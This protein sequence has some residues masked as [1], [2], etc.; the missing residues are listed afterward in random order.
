MGT[1]C[2]ACWL[3]ARVERRRVKQ[4]RP[5]SLSVWTQVVVTACLSLSG[6]LQALNI[7]TVLVERGAGPFVAGLWL[8]LIAAGLQ[9][10]YLVLVPLGRA[11]DNGWLC[12]RY[13]RLMVP[14]AVTARPPI[15]H[16]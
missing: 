2:V 13:A 8:L 5:G 16:S 14:V 7:G 12:K 10:A 6:V 1:F 4:L 9:F 15:K 3:Y 11:E